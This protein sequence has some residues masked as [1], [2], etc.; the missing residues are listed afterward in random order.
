MIDVA[1]GAD[2]LEN[3][4]A[5]WHHRAKLDC[6][7]HRK[8]LQV[9][10]VT[11]VK[12]SF[13]SGKHWLAVSKHSYLGIQLRL[14]SCLVNLRVINSERINQYQTLLELPHRRAGVGV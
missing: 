10:L 9:G 13:F 11:C 4:F 7:C 5:R 12:W 8:S 2:D 6:P 1:G 3:V 14:S